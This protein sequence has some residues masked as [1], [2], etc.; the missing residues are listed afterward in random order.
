MTNELM[1]NE[2]ILTEA[3]AIELFTGDAMEPLVEKV[4]EAVDKHVPDTSTAKGRGEIASLARKVA[5]T[6]VTLDN[7]GKNLVAD[8]K[9]KSAKVDMVRKGMRDELD[10]IRD[11]ARLPLTNWEQ[12]EEERKHREELDRQWDAAWDDA[13]AYNALW[14]REKAVRDREAELARLEADRK[15]KEEADRLER[16]RLDRLAKEAESRKQREEQI[17]REA[18]ERTQ[19]QATE[20]ADRQRR[21]HEQALAREKARAEKAEQDRIATE[22]RAKA[23]QE[24]AVLRAQQQA[25]MEAERKDRERLAEEKAEKDRQEKLAANRRHR[26]KVEHDAIDSATDAGLPDPEAWIAAIAEGKVKNVTINY[27]TPVP[28]RKPCL[29]L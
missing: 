18:A 4:R 27:A 11:Q 25:R 28:V 23:E 6:K 14:E 22:A 2:T 7:L 1:V 26:L 15:A 12:A 20:A 19:R 5:S 8:W 13:Q 24:A 21:E 29:S 3:Y 10:F 9:Q 17:A 16:E